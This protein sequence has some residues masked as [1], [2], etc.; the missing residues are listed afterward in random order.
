MVLTLPF[1]IVIKRGELIV[2]LGEGVLLV[3]EEKGPGG[4]SDYAQL[5]QCEL[6][7]PL[8]K[9]IWAVCYQY[10]K[11]HDLSILDIL[12]AVFYCCKKMVIQLYCQSVNASLRIVVLNRPIVLN[13][14]QT[15]SKKLNSCISSG[16]I[17][18]SQPFNTKTKRTAILHLFRLMVKMDVSSLLGLLI[19]LV[20]KAPV[21]LELWLQLLHL[22]TH[23]SY[24]LGCYE[25]K[26]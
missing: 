1:F 12:T 4:K 18:I 10:P 13:V 6:D 22:H 26:T 17:I 20:L 19:T 5:D 11:G 14:L 2:E 15:W 21:L 3:A 8:P 23:G 7:Q 9:R 24:R 16:A 25:T